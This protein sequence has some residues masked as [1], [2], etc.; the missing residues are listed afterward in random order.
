MATGDGAQVLSRMLSWY[1]LPTSM[2]TVT[3]TSTSTCTSVVI[4]LAEEQFEKDT[5]ILYDRVGKIQK[6]VAK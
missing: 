2:L 1:Q 4:L 3:T 6:D 5:K